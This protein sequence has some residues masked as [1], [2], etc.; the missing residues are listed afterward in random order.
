MDATTQEPPP[1]EDHRTPVVPEVEA[2]DPEHDID[3]KK[4]II[5]LGVGWVFVVVTMLALVKTFQF[6]VQGQQ[7]KVIDEL[8]PVELR[9]VRSDQDY[10]LKK[11]PPAGE[12]DQRS[13]AEIEQ[14][15]EMTTNSII[16]GYLNK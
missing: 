5:W 7:F 16:E 2:I 12:A 1:A 9:Q 15:I 8:P 3:A 13:L 4:T 14:S 11:M 6:A 10:I